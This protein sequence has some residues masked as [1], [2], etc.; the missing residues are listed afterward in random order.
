MNHMKTYFNTVILS[1]G[2]HFP[3]AVDQIETDVKFI[4]GSMHIFM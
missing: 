1:K 4:E 3:F 2:L